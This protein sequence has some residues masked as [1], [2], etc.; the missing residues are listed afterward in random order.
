MALHRHQPAR[1][2]TPI[3]TDITRRRPATTQRRNV[4]ARNPTCVF[5]G[6]RIPAIRSDLDHR[7][8]WADGGP[9]T[10]AN[11]GPLCRHDHNIRHQ[12]GWTY[13]PLPNSDHQ[14]TSRLGHTHT[15]SETPP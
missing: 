8:P 12:H 7:T 6:C 9:T 5:P 14:W 13:Q 2:S 3:H 11:L 4:E 10:E 15:T 1:R